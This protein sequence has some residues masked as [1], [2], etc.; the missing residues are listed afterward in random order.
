MSNAMYFSTAVPQGWTAN[1]IEAKLSVRSRIFPVPKSLL[2]QEQNLLNLLKTP[3]SWEVRHQHGRGTCN[4]FAAIAA[5]ELFRMI[6]GEDTEPSDLSEEH[7]YAKTRAVD[8]D[9]VPGKIPIAA[10]HEFDKT[11]GTFLAQ[12]RVALQEHG[13]A[14]EEQVPY[15]PSAAVNYVAQHIP[16]EVDQKAR[17]RRVEHSLIHDITD[18]TIGEGRLWW[19]LK[20]EIDLLLLFAYHLKQGFPV[21][22]SFAIPADCQYVWAGELAYATGQVRYPPLGIIGDRPAVAGHTVCLIGYVPPADP[23]D[24]TEGWF[25]F[26]NSYGTRL[27]GRY[28]KDFPENPNGGLPGYGF[29]SARDVNLYCWEFLIPSDQESL[30]FLDAAPT[31]PDI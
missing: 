30:F 13:M 1:N 22:A 2:P 19:R 26:R 8:Y 12:V 31:A 25:L 5:Q 14:L 16:E 23:A 18:A 28:A 7:L 15:R 21:V 27:F 9:V 10:Q 17:E 4:A 29:I 6:R 24:E 11:G 20:D 3:Q